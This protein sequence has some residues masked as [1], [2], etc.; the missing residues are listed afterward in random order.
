[1]TGVGLTIT[2]VSELVTSN[3]LDLLLL[4]LLLVA[5]HKMGPVDVARL[6]WSRCPYASEIILWGSL[7]IVLGIPG[8]IL[9]V[10]VPTYFGHEGYLT[11]V[12]LEVVHSA[13][14]TPCIEETLFRGL[15][16]GSLLSLGRIRAYSLSTLLFLIWH[17]RLVTLIV[18]GSPDLD[19]PH[20]AIIVVFGLV[21]A[22]IYEKT[23][24]L[25][26]CIIF[27]G[28]GNAFVTGRPLIMHYLFGSN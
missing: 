8:F 4:S 24:S 15:C 11:F 16:F 18:R 26:L 1:M 14:L 10:E 2:T 12:L 9:A 19:L 6:L 21:A 22:Y 17:V 7:G 27:H 23:N 25:A 13:I 20:A 28:A 5:L 3:L